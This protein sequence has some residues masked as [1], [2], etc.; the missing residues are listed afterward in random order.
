MLRKKELLSRIK[1]LESELSRHA[2]EIQMLNIAKDRHD[3]FANDVRR[4]LSDIRN[5]LAP[6]CDS[7]GH[8]I[9]GKPN[10]K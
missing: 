9:E 8:I 7:C 5:K 4:H 2:G 3:Y 6:K 10:D 1:D